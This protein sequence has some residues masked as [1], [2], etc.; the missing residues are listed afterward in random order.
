MSSEKTAVAAGVPPPVA[1]K[2]Y[3][4]WLGGESPNTHNTHRTDKS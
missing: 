3:P 2:P 1:K 4:F